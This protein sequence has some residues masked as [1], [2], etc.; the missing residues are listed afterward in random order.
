MVSCCAPGPPHFSV[1]ST[2]SS[3]RHRSGASPTNDP[4]VASMSVL[5]GA[6]AGSSTQPSPTLFVTN[7]DDKLKKP[8]QLRSFPALQTLADRRGGQT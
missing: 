8:G 6:A 3:A 2:F 7:L 4:T 5:N 1:R